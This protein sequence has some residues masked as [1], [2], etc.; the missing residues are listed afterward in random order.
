MDLIV[1]ASGQVKT[2]YSEQLDLHALG[3]LVITRASHV[4]P[5]ATGQWT[6]DLRPVGGPVL[7]PFPMRSDALDAEIAWLE[8]HWLMSIG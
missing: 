4:E 8:A 3:R 5:I 7:G 2:I 1:S 6:A